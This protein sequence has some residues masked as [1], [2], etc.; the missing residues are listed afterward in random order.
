MNLGCKVIGFDDPKMSSKEKGESLEDAARLYS[1]Y[2]ARGGYGLIFVRHPKAG[3]AQIVSN[4]S[5]VPVINCGDGPYEHPTQTLIDLYTIKKHKDRIDGLDICI[6]G[7]LKHGRTVH[8]LVLGL[9]KFKDI[10]ISLSPLEG[11]ELPGEW[12]EKITHP[13]RQVDLPL[14]TA[15]FDVVYVTRVQKEYLSREENDKVAKQNYHI[16]YGYLTYCNKQTLIM[17]PLP[18]DGEIN[19]E[20]DEDPRSIYFEQAANGVPVRMALIKHFLKR[21]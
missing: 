21:R 14:G 16:N 18:R 4:Y 19:P 3:S 17:H 13:C 9:E 8:S 2:V 20:I 11:L 1:G 5:E 7:D 12:L 10:Q 15:S 6:I